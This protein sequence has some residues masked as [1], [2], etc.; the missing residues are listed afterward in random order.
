MRTE[1]LIRAL[2][3]DRQSK[4]LPV[5]HAML[6]FLAAAAVINLPI[7]L[8]MGARA[9]LGPAM[10]TPQLLYKV[11]VAAGFSFVGFGMAHRLSHPGAR[12]GGWWWA[13]AGVLVAGV[14][15]VAVEL[16]TTSPTTWQARLLGVSWWRCMS[17]I[18]VLSLAPMA[19]YLLALR[20][21]A[22]TSPRLAG[23][24]AGLGASGIAAALYAIHCT[25]DSPLFVAV[26]YGLSIAAAV[27]LGVSAGSR[28]LR[29]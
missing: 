28:L 13:L 15:G 23:M 12:V 18:G 17:F 11:L 27:G 21:G 19:C 2:V 16:A 14:L 3:T 4:E 8:G 10:L 24:A 20:N 26:W 6:L 7:I 9:D 1:N 22:P 5:A 25:D 29:W